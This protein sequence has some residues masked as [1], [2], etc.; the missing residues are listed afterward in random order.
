MRRIGILVFLLSSTVPVVATAQKAPKRTPAPKAAPDTDQGNS[1]EPDVIVTGQR[2]L[3]GSVVGDIPPELTLSPA[4][5]RS[6]GV[7]SISDL[8]T[9]LAPQTTSGRG[10][11][12]APVVLLNG[13]QISSFTEIR[14]IPT[15]AILRVDILPEEVALKYGYDADQKVVNI[16]L[17]RRF[18]ATT[19]ELADKAATAGGRNNPDAEMDL[20]K[21]RGDGRLNLHMSY[22]ADTA[23]T[24]NERSIIEQPSPFAVGGNVIGLGALQPDKS[25]EIDPALSALA[26]M[27][28]TSAGVPAS[29][30]AGA[31]ALGAFVPTANLENNTNQGAYRTLLPSSHDFSANLVYARPIGKASATINA[32]VEATDSVSLNGLPGVSLNLPAGNP[33]S[34]FANAVTIDRALDGYLPLKQRNSAI[35]EHVGT[36]FNGMMGK[37]RWSVTGNYDRSDSET[38]TDTGLDISAFQARIT[39][40]DPTANPFGSLANAGIAASPANRA[41]STSNNAGADALFSGP[42]FELPA[43]PLY[44]SIRVGGDISDLSS[45]SYRA[46]LT[47]TADIKRNV[48]NGQ[49]NVDVPITS[50]SKHFLGAIGSLSLN[51]NYAEDHLSDFGNLQTIGYGANWSPI[52][53]VRII[54]SATDQDVAPSAVQLGNPTI[55]TPNVRVFDYIQ[56]TTAT[57]TT[58][59]G[60]NPDLIADKT[61]VRKIGLTVKPWK[62]KDINFTANYVTNRTDN[63][64][65]AFPTPTAAIEAAFPGRFTRDSSGTLTRLDNRPINF[66][67]S[68]SSQLR[69]G[70]NFS[71][72]LK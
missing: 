20:L 31:P 6:Y 47:Q 23:L 58:L 45:R 64:I 69:W 2:N 51:F 4:D 32:R 17:R 19:V 5:I 35:T 7:S 41:F 44:T 3:P 22:Q 66:A 33:F 10:S 30:A 16:V 27:P 54:A 8:L 55:T 26:G 14:D 18:R 70:I 71:V 52:E 39:A 12:G 9:E 36:T 59:S 67:E 13:K 62:A 63:P 15:E 24:E 42:V 43:G 48:V 60:G 57:V 53:A 50:R 61:Q 37:W 29:A 11:G 34:P 56:G 49:L 68:E 46:G 72:P 1:D 28:V 65:A 21:I 38:W 40:G 25:H